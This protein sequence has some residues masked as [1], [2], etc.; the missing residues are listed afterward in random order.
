MRFRTCY[1]GENDTTPGGN[2][3]DEL[4]KP[5]LTQEQFNAAI[6]KEKKAWQTKQQQL[7]Q[8]LDEIKKSATMTA[9]Q[10]TALEQQIEE[11]RNA[12]LSVEERARLAKEKVEKEWKEKYEASDGQAQTWR[13][14]HDDL[15]ISH[16]LRQAA[17][18]AGVLPNSIKF[19]EAVL[20]PLTRLV[21]ENDDD[22]Q[23]AGKYTVKIKFSDKTKEGK[24]F[25]GDYTIAETLARMKDTPEEYGSLFETD[26]KGGLGANN[27]QPGKK[28][29]L[30]NM[31]TG[32]Y[33]RRRREDPASVGK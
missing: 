5:T 28:T 9:E 13:K 32:E 18:E 8:Q 10:K 23:P 3:N 25:M 4:N 1:E 19:V 30:K 14:R 26:K 21:E 6:A 11:L 31:P 12:N 33:I 22:G 29:N 7:A 24:P 15:K 16:D 17:I 27:G 2:G 20:R